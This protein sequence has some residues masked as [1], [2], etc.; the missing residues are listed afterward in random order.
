MEPSVNQTIATSESITMAMGTLNVSATETISVR[1]FW[2]PEYIDLSTY[3]TIELGEYTYVMIDTITLT[4]C[5]DYP[6][7]EIGTSKY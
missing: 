6:L 5:Y 1:D 4:N 7:G 3:D 2:I